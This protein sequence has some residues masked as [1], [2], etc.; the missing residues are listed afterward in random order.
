M[1]G[2]LERASWTGLGHY[3][4]L[5][6]LLRAAVCVSDLPVSARP[7]AGS[8]R[9]WAVT[10]FRICSGRQVPATHGWQTSLAEDTGEIGFPFFYVPFC[11]FLLLIEISK[12]D[13]IEF[14]SF[15]NT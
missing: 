13:F 4:S 5:S 6:S 10:V 3:S 8:P 9:A 12:S 2:I 11:L 14:K 7:T 1:E 15:P